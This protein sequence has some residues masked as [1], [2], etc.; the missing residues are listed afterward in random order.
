[1]FYKWGHFA[2]RHRRVIP[3]VVI[4]LILLMQ[5]LFG[6]KL[7][8]RLSQEGW[9]DPG[10][11]STTAAQIEYDTFGRDNSGDVILLVTAPDGAEVLQRLLAVALSLIHI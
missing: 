7:A 9:E 10:A 5:V 6:S 8:D 1:M 3:V 4:A 2:H 11:D